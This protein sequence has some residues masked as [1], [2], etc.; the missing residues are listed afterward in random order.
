MKRLPI[1]ISDF[2]ELIENDYLF[3]DTTPLIGEIYREP[4][5]IL[6]IT[7]PRRFGKT[8]N[9]SMLFYFFDNTCQSEELFQGLEI[10]QV[11]E[12][13][14]QINAYPVIFLSFKDIKDRDWDD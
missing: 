7:R 6:L 14:K 1:G 5:K 10:I 3:A 11:E 9:M 2:K 13:M 12:V 8:L 4:S